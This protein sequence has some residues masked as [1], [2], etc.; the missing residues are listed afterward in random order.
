MAA[1]FSGLRLAGARALPV[2]LVAMPSEALA[3]DGFY[4]LAFWTTLALVVGIPALWLLS[5]VV[6]AALLSLRQRRMA[7]KYRANIV[8]RH[9]WPTLPAGVT[10][11]SVPV[12]WRREV[13]RLTSQK[14]VDLL[15]RVSRPYALQHVNSIEYQG[16]VFVRTHLTEAGVTELLRRETAGYGYV[17]SASLDATQPLG[18]VPRSTAQ[19]PFESWLALI[20]ASG[21]WLRGWLGRR[22]RDRS[23]AADGIRP[24]PGTVLMGALRLLSK[25]KHF[26]RVFNPI[27]SDFY[28]EYAEAVAAGEVWRSRWTTVR[29]YY[30]LAK[31]LMFFRLVRLVAHFISEVR[32][33]IGAQD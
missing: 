9:Y 16:Q 10:A 12:F 22:E 7:R 19:S 17:S 28:E 18:L 11:P 3:L 14:L 26:D 29:F 30:D 13:R 6:R 5:L 23:S 2:G 25:P 33:A 4:H 21:R 1:S 31:A 8:S 24:A 15:Q 32:A 27:Y 20:S